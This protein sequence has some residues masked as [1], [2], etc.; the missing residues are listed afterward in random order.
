MWWNF[1]A[2]CGN[3]S[4]NLSLL[5]PPQ[6]G[7]SWLCASKPSG[8]QCCFKHFVCACP[9][10]QAPLM[11]IHA[12]YTLSKWQFIGLSPKN[13]IVSCNLTWTY[14]VTPKIKVGSNSAKWAGHRPSALS[15]NITRHCIILKRQS[16]WWT[17]ALSGSCIWRLFIKTF[18]KPLSLQWCIYGSW[19]KLLAMA[20][21][22]C[23]GDFWWIY[24]LVGRIFNQLTQCE[25]A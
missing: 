4:N 2:H 9:W 3:L 16:G 11:R 21:F 12:P 20:L 18:I 19:I 23:A 22:I 25:L 13:K 5:W 24:S 6:A 1:N 17:F 15:Y 14:I 10:L 8:R 7:I